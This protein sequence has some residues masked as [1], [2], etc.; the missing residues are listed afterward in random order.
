MSTYSMNML[1]YFI[2]Y[3]RF[4]LIWHILN[5]Q[6]SIKVAHVTGVEEAKH[7]VEKELRIWVNRINQKSVRLERVKLE[8]DFIKWDEK[9]SSKDKDYL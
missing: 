3:N 1:L 8:V 2:K 5:S 9:K 4:E 7:T 6:F